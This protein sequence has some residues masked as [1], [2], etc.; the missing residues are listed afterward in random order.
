MGRGFLS[1]SPFPSVGIMG[2]L[3]TRSWGIS[4]QLA[5]T[6]PEYM[7]SPPLPSQ[8]QFKVDREG[9]LSW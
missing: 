3:M 9:G 4:G 5:P 7:L 6:N 2:P 8:E 1:L